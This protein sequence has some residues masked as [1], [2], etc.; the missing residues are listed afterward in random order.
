MI[1]TFTVS[2]LAFLAVLGAASAQAED[3]RTP[4]QMQVSV[5]HVDFDNAA[6]VH[7]LYA[8]LGAAAQ[9]VCDSDVVD[10]PLTAMADKACER[11]AVS[12][13]VRQINQPQLSALDG[14]ST[15]QMAQARDDGDRMPSV[16][17][18]FGN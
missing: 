18:F 5:A 13:A 2:A 17:T 7:R 12:D 14:Q 10:G 16:R 4:A 15:T 9:T 8:R 11:A 3:A 6:Q 1:R